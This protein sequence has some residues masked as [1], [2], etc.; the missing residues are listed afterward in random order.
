MLATKA[1]GRDG[2][3]SYT[4]ARV[5]GFTQTG[6]GVRAAP[7][8]GFIFWRRTISHVTSAATFPTESRR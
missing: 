7:P 5:P 6:S 3:N 1:L 2:E 4:G 8:G